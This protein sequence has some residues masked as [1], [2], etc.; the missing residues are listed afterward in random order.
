MN[1]P[2]LTRIL[3]DCSST[4]TCEFN[5]GIQRVVRSICQQAIERNGAISVTPICGRDEQFYPVQS[6]WPKKNNATDWVACVTSSGVAQLY[7]KTANFIFRRVPN[8]TLTKLLLPEQ[9]HSGI[10]KLPKILITKLQ[11]R[12]RKFQTKQQLAFQH[13]EI[14]R[15][16]VILMADASWQL[17]NWDAIEL[18]RARG[19][20]VGNLIYDLIPLT[21][22]QFFQ[23][24]LV[25]RFTRWFHRAAATGD[26]FLCISECVAEQMQ[27]QLL[28]FG[29]TSASA[30]RICVSFPLGAELTQWTP[31]DVSP[32]VVTLFGTDRSANPHLVV[33][34]LEPRKNHQFVLDAFETMWRAGSKERLCIAGRL[35]W[36]CESLVQRIRNHPEFNR[37]LFMNNLASDADIGFGYENA[38]SVIMASHTEGFGLPIVEALAL[39][40]TVLASDTPIHREVGR[41]QIHYFAI[42][43]TSDSLID[44]IQKLD[45]S[46]SVRLKQTRPHEPTAWSASFDAVVANIRN[47]VD[48]IN[49][50]EPFQS[51]A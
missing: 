36:N 14:H 51:A 40:Q 13:I 16:D 38:K 11:K 42:D 39:G 22:P 28:R 33:G 44:A 27:S 12:Y 8:K 45:S 46:D 35:G 47:I 24:E 10:F 37:L 15:G 49:R 2:N 20:I 31:K 9:G 3:I 48:Q 21:H 18:A 32:E 26:F 5:S 4:I 1:S 50:V 43:S 6:L 7:R 34:T 19:A 41:D 17:P 29:H 25:D 23:P 30:K